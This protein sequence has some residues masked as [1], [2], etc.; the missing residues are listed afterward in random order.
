[1][2][3]TSQPMTTDLSNSSTIFAISAARRLVA[4]GA[5][6]LALASAAGCAG[7]Q[8]RATSRRPTVVLAAEPGACAP[9]AIVDIDNPGHCPVQLVARGADREFLGASAW[10]RA[11]Q[12]DASYS[13]PERFSWIVLEVDPLCDSAVGR[14]RYRP[15][16]SSCEAGSA[17]IVSR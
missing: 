12:H 1:M 8:R 6:V 17:T 5:L 15:A 4:G 7:A 10:I 16:P 11:G 2:N 13:L 14:I 9:A 3:K